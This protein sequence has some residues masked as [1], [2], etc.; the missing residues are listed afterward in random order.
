VHEP[1]LGDVGQSDGP[2]QADGE[3]L[4]VLVSTVERHVAYQLGMDGYVAGDAVVE[5]VDLK[6][7]EKI[8]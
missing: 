2:V 6:K 8:V 3:Q 4:L 7:F 1:T 5:E